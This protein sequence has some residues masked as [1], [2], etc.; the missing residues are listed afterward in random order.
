MPAPLTNLKFNLKDL[1]DIYVGVDDIEFFT[2]ELLTELGLDILRTGELYSWGSNDKGQSGTGLVT[3]SIVLP[4]KVGMQNNW[5][6]LA[7]GYACSFAIKDDGTLWS[8]GY[9]N[10]G[11]L[12]LGDTIDRP[13]PTQIGTDNDWKQVSSRS[14]AVFAIKEN[15]TLWAWGRN[16]DGRLGLGDLVDRSSPTIVDSFRGLYG[17]TSVSAGTFHANATRFSNN[18]L[19][20]WGVNPNG[21]LGLNNT[22]SFSTPQFVSSGWRKVEASY[23]FSAGLKGNTLYAWGRNQFGQL[24][25]NQITNRS[26]PVQIGNAGGWSDIAL[27]DSHTIATGVNG[28]IFAWGRN[29]YGQLGVG[30]VVNRSSPTQI[31]TSTVWRKIFAGNY[32]TG[33]IKYDGTLWVWGKDTNAYGSGQLG[34]GDGLNRSSPTLINNLQDWRSLSIG[35]NHMLAIRK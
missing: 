29:H 16:N 15:G 30:T 11:Q 28:A 21:E 8:W 5:N 1:S 31:G 7:R 26:S 13:T 14:T 17:W 3:P 2:E 33:A 4:T 12:G 22:T 24:G 9:N 25:N 23:R 6:S 34:L 18:E 20:T 35:Y 10:R 32:C 19:W 27:G